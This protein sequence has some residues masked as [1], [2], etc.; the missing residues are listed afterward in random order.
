MRSSEMTMRHTLFL[1][2]FLP[3]PIIPVLWKHVRWVGFGSLPH[4]IFSSL[5]FSTYSLKRP[6]KNGKLCKLISIF[7]QKKEGEELGK[8][9][10][11]SY[12]NP[13]FSASRV[14]PSFFKGGM[15]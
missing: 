8:M 12:V 7:E 15:K 9:L 5:L 14:P 6:F 13:S 3:F 1:F 4:S 2:L 11:S 10:I